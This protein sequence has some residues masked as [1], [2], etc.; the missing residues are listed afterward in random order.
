MKKLNIIFVIAIAIL[1]IVIIIL[2]QKLN[3]YEKKYVAPMDNTIVKFDTSFTGKNFLSIIK[4]SM[5]KKL[6]KRYNDD[7]PGIP[8]SV[9][10]QGD[11]LTKFR[12]YI[13]ASDVFGLRVYLG[14]YYNNDSDGDDIIK[15]YIKDL[16][17]N[18][19]ERDKYLK[20]YE[21]TITTVILATTDMNGNP[22]TDKLIN[23]GGLCPPKCKPDGYN[24]ENDV[25]YK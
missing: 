9:F 11:D 20:N 24:P 19:D 23:L 8:R 7:N 3:E 10:F 14:R 17:N 2:L 5:A 12:N 22:I 13:N 1:T 16:F 25:L 21:K 18:A 6:V 15:D 4:L